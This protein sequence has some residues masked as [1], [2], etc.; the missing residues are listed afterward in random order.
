M[1]GGEFLVSSI[2]KVSDGFFFLKRFDVQFPL[3][4]KID[5]CLEADIIG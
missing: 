4:P 5:W 3:I 1:E 2:G